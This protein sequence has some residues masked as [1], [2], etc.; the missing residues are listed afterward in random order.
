MPLLEVE[1]LVKYYGNRAVVNGV[2]FS[3]DA[4]EVVGLLGPNG[5]GKTTSFRMATGQ[6]QPNDGKVTFN[7]ED[8]T[9]LAM[10]Q[11][12]RRGMGYL[13]QEPSVFR[14]LSVEGNLLAILEALPR[15]RKL[16]RRLS[17]AERWER[18]NEA[19]TRFKLDP[20]RKTTAGRCS[21][22]EKRRLEIA[23]CLVCEPMLIL[24]DEPFAAVDPITTEDIRRNI[25]E[26]AD[27]GIGILITDHNVREVFRTADRVYL[28]TAGKVV[29]RGTPME[30]VNDPVAIDAYLGR[31]FEEDG[32]T[33]HFDARATKKKSESSTST[34]AAPPVVR[35]SPPASRPVAPV[36]APAPS[37]APTTTLTAPSVFPAAP[38]SPFS[39]PMTTTTPPPVGQALGGPMAA[40]LELEKI[41]RAVEGLA[42][43]RT[44]KASMVE[45]VAR[46][47]AAIPALLEAMERRDAVLRNRAFEVLKFVAKD[48][49]ALDYDPNAT[50]ESRLRQVAHL[51][52]K[53]ERRR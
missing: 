31:S 49:G 30:L 2:S 13:S 36:E 16:G 8:V 22:G 35:Y 21:G 26:L 23:R 47:A 33:R 4:G 11:R 18:T 7:D 41:R 45:L 24:L 52:A 14:K 20:V 1:G 3:V 51:R 15:S 48:S 12:A 6:I 28:I 19:L 39:A 37:A 44:L 34:L 38:P 40:V 32:F 42:D 27:S 50:T 43:D 53:L 17:R 5:A 25:R 29:T 9:S 46:G 10:Y